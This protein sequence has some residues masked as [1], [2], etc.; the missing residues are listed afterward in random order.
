MCT[1]R[2]KQRDWLTPKDT[3]SPTVMTESVLILAAIDAK[4]KEM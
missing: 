1:N 2:S 3:L 4:E